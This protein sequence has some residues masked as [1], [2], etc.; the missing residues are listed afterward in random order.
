YAKVVIEAFE[1]R[2]LYGPVWKALGKAGP[3]DL[4]ELRRMD[5]SPLRAGLPERE[6]TATAVTA[7]IP[8]HPQPAQ[9]A[10]P[11]IAPPRVQQSK[12]KGPLPTPGAKPPKKP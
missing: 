11:P 8:T 10:K 3:V 5:W 9:G 6:S 4:D 7:L 2:D 1:P 12:V